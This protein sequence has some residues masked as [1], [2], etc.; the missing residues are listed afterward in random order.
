MNMDSMQFTKK[1]I[2]HIMLGLYIIGSVG[3]IGYIQW[4]TFKT[5]YSEQAFQ[6]GQADA[7]SQLITQAENP[8]CQA[9]SVYSQ[10]KEVQL[11]NVACLQAA[12]TETGE[13]TTTT[14]TTTTN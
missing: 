13:A 3:Y 6:S 10:Q 11:V 5:N 8:N 1:Q 12:T 4:T 7:I 9:F 2:V 14:D